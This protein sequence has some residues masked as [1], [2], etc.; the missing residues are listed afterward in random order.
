MISTVHNS[1]FKAWWFP[2]Y[3][4]MV[5]E[6]GIEVVRKDINSYSWI[7]RSYD[8]HGSLKH[9]IKISMKVWIEISNNCDIFKLTINDFKIPLKKFNDFPIDYTEIICSK[10]DFSI[11]N[12]TYHWD[13]KYFIGKRNIIVKAGE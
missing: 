6:K 11:K 3:V 4:P 5:Y 10:G 9:E 8:T 2:K 12:S 1:E 13:S 7:A